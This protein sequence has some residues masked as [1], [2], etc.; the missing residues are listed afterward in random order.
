MIDRPYLPG[1]YGEKSATSQS[2]KVSK[3][4][5]TAEVWPT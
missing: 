1:Q 3:L 4:E 5:Q 2:S